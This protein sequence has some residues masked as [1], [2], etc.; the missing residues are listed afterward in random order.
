MKRSARK[1]VATLAVARKLRDLA[2]YDMNDA[3]DLVGL[4]RRR[5]AGARFLSAF[6]LVLGGVAVGTVLGMMLAPRAGRDLRQGLQSMP[7]T[8]RPGAH[9]GYGAQPVNVGSQGSGFSS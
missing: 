4:R 9:G 5:S 1:G 8:N 3:L 6:G 7:G 2:D